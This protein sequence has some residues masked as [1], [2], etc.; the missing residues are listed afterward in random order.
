MFASSVVEDL[1]AF[2][3][4]IGKFDAGA[5]APS[6]LESV[7]IVPQNDSI[8]GSS[9][10]SPTVPIDGKRSERRAQAVKAHELN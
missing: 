4:R 7:C 8:L 1:H 10:Q 6:V 9:M 2:D 3:D 5:P